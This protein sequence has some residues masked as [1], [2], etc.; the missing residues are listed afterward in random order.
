M[1]RPGQTLLEVMV[2]ITIMIVGIISLVSLL[3]A[4]Q[5]TAHLSYQEAIAVQLGREAVEAAHFVRDTNWLERDNGVAAEFDDGLHGS[6]DPTDYTAIYRW[7]SSQTDPSQ[8]L[9]FD[10]TPD[11]ITDATTTLYTDST[12]NYY[13]QKTG[14]IPG[15]WEKTA[16][17]R[18]ITFY[19]ICS[20]DAGITESI[21]TT[22][23]QTCA[24]SYPGTLKIGVQ[25]AVVIQ[26]QANDLTHARVLE[27]RLY[28]WKY[29]EANEPVYTYGS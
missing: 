12:T 28:N 14:T 9:T 17:Q 16:F 29:T 5:T 27:E 20:A 13:L 10:F 11:T 18:F 4:T 24:V 2:S 8:A 21:L 26:W 23:G 22:D 15:T 7:Q 3:I 6:T 1:Q 25:V 19:P